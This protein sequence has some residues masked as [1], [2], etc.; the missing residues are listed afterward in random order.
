M[1]QYLQ[2]PYVDGGR[3]LDGLDCWGL[4]LAVRADMGLPLLPDDP[5]AIRG[6]GA[7]VAR[8]F[9]EVSA[10]LVEGAPRPGALAAVFR[11]PL[12]MHVGVVVEADGRLWVLETNP[13]VGV[14]LRRLAHFAEAHYKVVYYCDRDLPEPA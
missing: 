9:R 13:G 4:A 7:E 6:H 8:L 2:V 12:F 10:L 1:N 5:L 3:T 14:H 11:G